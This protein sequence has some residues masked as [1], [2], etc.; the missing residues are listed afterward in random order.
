MA[1]KE[2]M[3]KRDENE[4]K[5]RTIKK[6]LIEN[7][8]EAGIN[9]FSPENSSPYILSIEGTLP[10]EVFTRMLMDKGFCVSSG[11]ACSNNAKGKSESILEAMGISNQRATR[12][13]RISLSRN[14]T[15]EEAEL[16]MKAIK[17]IVNG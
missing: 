2:W 12:A 4:K 5:A 11:S 7:L 3:E 10:S 17:E 9:I 13:V 8:Q 1:L 6:Y 14:S 16:L 15:I